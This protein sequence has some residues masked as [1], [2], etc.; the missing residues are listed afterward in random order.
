MGLRREP[1]KF[2]IGG[3]ADAEIE[4]DHSG[5]QA[6]MK[7]DDAECFLAEVVDEPRKDEKGEARVRGLAG[8]IGQEI[9]LR[10]GEVHCVEF[11]GVCSASLRSNSRRRISIKASS[12]VRRALRLYW[13][14]IETDTEKEKR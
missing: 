14:L 6:N 2:A 11:A 12:W 4:E 10:S 5:L 9:P 8:E 7:A 1:G 13:R 3:D